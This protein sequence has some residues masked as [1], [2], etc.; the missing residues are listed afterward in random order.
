MRSIPALAVLLLLPLPALADRAG[1]LLASL[2]RD[3][4]GVL[5]R[6]E[7]ADGGLFTA[8]DRDKD[9]R[10]TRD[11]IA[12]Y[13]EGEKPAPKEPG[14]EPAAP[15]PKESTSDGG[16]TKEPR[17]IAERLE[18]FFRRLD[19]DK[20]GKVSAEEFPAGEEVLREYDRTRDK[21]LNRREAERYIRDQVREAKRRPRPDNF[22][23]LFDLDRDQRVRRS[24]YDGPPEF[25]RD[26]DHD[27]DRVV[28]EEEIAMGRMS[29][30]R[31]MEE[32]AAAPEDGPTG[33]PERGL[34]ERFDKNGDKRVTLEELGGAESIFERLDR[35]GDGVLSGSEVR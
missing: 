30:M 1:D 35:N 15:A 26:Y 27:R 6:A 31:G 11:E 34:L 2:D 9:G 19:A 13:L 22:F 29:A 33:L 20:D 24:E 8:I 12:R 28:T 14:K 4:D 18:D 21:A 25:F 5:T 16:V 7:V 3:G 17:S 23:Q 10:L 32:A